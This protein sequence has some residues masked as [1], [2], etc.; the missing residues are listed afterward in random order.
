MLSPLRCV[1]EG[2]TLTVDKLLL[3]RCDDADEMSVQAS[4]VLLRPQP[5][6]SLRDMQVAVPLKLGPAV[7]TPL[8]ICIP[9]QTQSFL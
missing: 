5:G 6:L 3:L 2:Q 4:A 7:I 1:L 8:L 9:Q